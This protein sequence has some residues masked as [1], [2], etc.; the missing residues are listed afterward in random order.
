[1]EEPDR[2]AHR[3]ARV[4]TVDFLHSRLPGSLYDVIV[5]KGKLASTA[6]SVT[7]ARVAPRSFVLTIG[8]DIAPGVPPERLL[9]AISDYVDTLSAA[10]IP[11]ETVERLKKRFLDARANADRHPQQVYNRLV[12]WLANHN[13]YEDLAAWP[14]RVAAVSPDE[15]AGIVRGLSGSGRVVT[16]ML[17]PAGLEAAQ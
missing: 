10:G 6:P 11:A 8:A 17:V 13:R 16:G 5:E 12:T 4:I 7:I 1:M 9:A 3:A 15:V 14:Q 2:V